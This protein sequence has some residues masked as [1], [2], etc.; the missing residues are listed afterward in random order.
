MTALSALREWRQFADTFA[1]TWRGERRTWRRHVQ[2]G[3]YRDEDRVV[4]PSAFPAFASEL[5]GFSVGVDLA[6]EESG[7][8]GRPDFTPADSVTHPFVFE[9]KGT[10]EETRLTGHQ[11]QLLRYLTEGRPRIR[12]GRRRDH[13]R[14]RRF[15]R[16]G[17]STLSRSV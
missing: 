11:Q 4:Q 10:D 2:G 15:L 13:R 7:D 3:G 14:C 9:T 1:V 5:L 17:A 12:K 16:E 6:P 8:E